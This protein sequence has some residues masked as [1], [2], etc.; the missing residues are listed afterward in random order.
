MFRRRVVGENASAIDAADA[1]QI[2][3]HQDDIRTRPANGNRLM[4]SRALSSRISGLRAMILDQHQ[5]RGCP[6]H[7]AASQLRAD[8]NRKLGNAMIPPV[9]RSCGSAVSVQ[10]DPE[11]A[12]FATVLSSPIDPHPSTSRLATT[13]PMPVPFLDVAP[14]VRGD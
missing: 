1:G 3:V 10:F 7:K 8:F 4:P 6:R 14:P 5:V 9:A 11:H 12:A 2:D 13:R